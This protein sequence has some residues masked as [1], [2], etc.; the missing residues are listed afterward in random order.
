MKNE[1]VNDHIHLLNEKY[2]LLSKCLHMSVIRSPGK[3]FSVIRTPGK[4]FSVIRTPGKLFSVIST[5]GKLTYTSQ[6]KS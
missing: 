4:L 5:P 1:L 2:F 3:L 6:M